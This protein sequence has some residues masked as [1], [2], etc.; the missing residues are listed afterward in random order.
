MNASTTRS[1]ARFNL[2][3]FKLTAFLLPDRQS[4]SHPSQRAERTVLVLDRDQSNLECYLRGSAV[5]VLV[6][7][8]F[9]AALSDEMPRLPLW[10]R[11]AGSIVA[12]ALLLNVLMFI[13]AVPLTIARRVF[14][15]E[16]RRFRGLQT[17][18]HEALLLVACLWALGQ[19][20]WARAAALTW[21]TLVA[22]NLSAA[23]ALRLS[24]D[25]VRAVEVR[26]G[27]NEFVN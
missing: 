16:R 26:R 19:E 20:P 25:S 18:I 5:F 1:P 21:L 22:L 2:A 14:Q 27:G 13:L 17:A 10:A 12:S 7:I 23:I 4:P 11:L 3:L 24:A 9:M 8:F 6:T 15:I